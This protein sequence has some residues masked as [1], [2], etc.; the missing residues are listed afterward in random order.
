MPFHMEVKY[1]FFKLI[2]YSKVTNMPSVNYNCF[3]I[4]I[5]IIFMSKNIDYLLNTYFC[6]VFIFI[7]LV[8]FIAQTRIVY[9]LGQ[10]F[11]VSGMHDIH[12][13]CNRI[14]NKFCFKKKT[15]RECKQNII[16]ATECQ[17]NNFKLYIRI[18]IQNL[19]FVFTVYLS[20]Y[21]QFLTLYYTFQS[22]TW[23]LRTSG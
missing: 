15:L 7:L 22:S 19:I 9:S 14:Q 3:Y 11:S 5:T 13:V 18:Q 6:S 17:L 20:I 12:V 8:H 16:F 1:D 10:G 4:I 21:V 2:Y 23:R